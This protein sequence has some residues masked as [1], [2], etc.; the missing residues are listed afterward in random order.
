MPE[1]ENAGTGASVLGASGTDRA[2]KPIEPEHKVQDSNTQPVVP[3][4][5]NRLPVL[6]DEINRAHKQARAAA[7][8]SLKH[9]MEAGE[10]LL[11]AKA[12]IGH[13]GWLEWLFSNVSFSQRTAQA[14]MRLASKKDDLK[15]KSAA[16]ADLTIECAVQAIAG[17][18]RPALQPRMMMFTEPGETWAEIEARVGILSSERGRDTILVT[19]CPTQEGFYY[20]A[21]YFHPYDF[22]DEA[23]CEFTKRPVRQDF[24]RAVIEKL[25]PQDFCGLADWYQPSREQ[26]VALTLAAGGNFILPETAAEFVLL[27]LKQIDPRIK[28]TRTSLDLPEDLPFESWL[29]VGKALEGLVGG[30]L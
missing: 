26:L 16:T 13:G 24:V 6:A 27:R 20:V 9:A 28:V 10:R 25:T 14:Y 18:S 8:T 2:A 12:T 11:E 15:L 29:A 5:D 22:R 17:P 4:G 1:K 21:H 23:P 19:P 30:E 7:R 3:A